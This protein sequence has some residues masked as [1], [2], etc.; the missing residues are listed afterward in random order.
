[1]ASLRL[2]GAACTCAA[3]PQANIDYVGAGFQAGNFYYCCHTYNCGWFSDGGFVLFDSACN[4][5]T[6]SSFV[7]SSTCCSL[8]FGNSSSGGS[9]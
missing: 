3:S 9:R 2:C 5:F 1:M 6:S 8:A 7:L 4:G